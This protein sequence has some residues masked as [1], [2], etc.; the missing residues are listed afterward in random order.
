MVY[1]SFQ[2]RIAC[3]GPEIEVVSTISQR[4]VSFDCILAQICIDSPMP[5]ANG[6]HAFL[7]VLDVG[8]GHVRPK[9]RTGRLHHI[10]LVCICLRFSIRLTG[11]II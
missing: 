10:Y 8:M 5:W 7:T 6:D 9:M 11:C 4:S 3:P 2:S 1:T